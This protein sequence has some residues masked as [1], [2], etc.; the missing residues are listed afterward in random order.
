MTQKAIDALKSAVELFDKR[1]QPLEKS[2]TLGK[3]A[4]IE[5]SNGFDAIARRHWVTFLLQ[6]LQETS[7]HRSK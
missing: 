3:L 4:C 6:I 7:I 1:Q 2:W 5:G